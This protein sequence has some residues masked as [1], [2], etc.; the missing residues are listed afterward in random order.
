MQIIGLSSEDGNW[1]SKSY[2]PRI[3]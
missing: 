1:V 2:R 3:G